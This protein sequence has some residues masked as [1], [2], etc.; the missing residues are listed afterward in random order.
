MLRQSS[1]ARLCLVGALSLLCS[2]ARAGPPL[3]Y[4]AAAT[5]GADS[6]AE[7]VERLRRAAEDASETLDQAFRLYERAGPAVGSSAKPFPLADRGE[8]K[9]LQRS[10][11]SL[12]VAHWLDVKTTL[13][14]CLPEA[15]REETSCGRLGEEVARSCDLEPSSP[16]INVRC[17]T[18][19]R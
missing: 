6:E 11:F 3:D 7:R 2:T 14:G 15:R 9:R 10:F 13:C 8:A 16:G 5:A 19:G 1:R 12:T 4:C 17:L 18:K